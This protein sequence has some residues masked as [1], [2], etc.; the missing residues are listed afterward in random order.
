[1]TNQSEV[2]IF[3][4]SEYRKGNANGAVWGS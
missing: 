3:T 4:R 2:S 1:M